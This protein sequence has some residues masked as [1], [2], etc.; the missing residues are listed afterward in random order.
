MKRREAGFTLTEMMIVVAIIGIL[1]TM[2][3]VY[4]RPRLRPI[5]VAN[6]VGDL[7]REASRR[8]VALGPVRPNVAV[9]LQSKARTQITAQQP[10]ATTIVFTLWRLQEDPLGAPTA[11][12]I[13]VETYTV[14]LKVVVIDSW[15][16]GVVDYTAAT[17]TGN[18]SAWTVVSAPPPTRTPLQCRP[19]GTCDAV[20]VFFQSALPGP[21]CNP[22]PPPTTPLLEQCGK[23]AVMPLGGAISTRTD[24]N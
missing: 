20:T 22:V 7:V 5:D 18:W 16:T 9:A 14:D 2:A 12:W 23:L 8:A 17:R 6:R 4:L 11:V 13:A 1:V 10:T 21:S 15:S 3:I 19:D 24:W